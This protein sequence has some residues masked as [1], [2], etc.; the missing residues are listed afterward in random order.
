[1][2]IQQGDAN[3]NLAR[4]PK[5]AKAKC[6]Q[7]DDCGGRFKTKR[8][9]TR[10]K[11]RKNC[12]QPFQCTG[13]SKTFKLEAQLKNHRKYCSGTTHE[14][15]ECGKVLKNFTQL[16]WH[17]ELHANANAFGCNFCDYKATRPADLRVHKKNVHGEVEDNAC[18]VCGDIFNNP[19][20]LRGH[21][22]IHLG[23]QVFQCGCG[24]AFKRK[25]YLE[26]HQATHLPKESHFSCPVC[27]KTFA[28][29]DNLKNHLQSHRN[30]AIPCPECEFSFTNLNKLW[31][32]IDKKHVKKEV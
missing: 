29:V 32:H 30:N 14:C 2:N 21:N 26:R 8:I 23:A 6:H 17:L 9:L 7:C 31:A 3:I 22:N 13:C 19:A 28:R 12:D 5:E 1:M 24:K 4:S 20:S 15:E 11:E 10:H 27:Q 16:K 18:N 25:D